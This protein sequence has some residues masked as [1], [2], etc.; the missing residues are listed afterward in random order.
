VILSFGESKEMTEEIDKEADEIEDGESPEIEIRLGQSSVSS[1]SVP[2]F[3]CVSK[4]WLKKNHPSH[5]RL[6]VSTFPLCEKSRA[7]KAE[8]REVFKLSD[9]AG[10]VTF[11]RG[12][13]CRI[14]AKVV[15]G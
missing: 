1:G 10:Y 12:G 8:W 4:E 15:R 5:F 7:V 6:Q 11:Y 14:A 9:M 3:W 13:P 2:I